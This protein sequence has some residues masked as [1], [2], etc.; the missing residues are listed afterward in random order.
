M[1]K[2]ALKIIETAE[3]ITAMAEDGTATLDRAIAAWPADFQAIIWDA[4]AALAARRAS[5]L[6]Q[7]QR[8]G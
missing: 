7:G 4:V 1:S 2:H 8:D 3:R 5:Q 6:R